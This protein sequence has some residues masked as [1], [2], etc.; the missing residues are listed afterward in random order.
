MSVVS[1][2]SASCPRSSGLGGCW[3]SISDSAVDYSN[4]YSQIV[5]AV[6]QHLN[7][8]G[9][10]TIGDIQSYGLDRIMQALGKHGEYF[11]RIANGEGSIIIHEHRETKSISSESTFAADV[12]DYELI[13]EKL[14]SLTTRVHSQLKNSQFFYKTITLKIRFED[15]TTFS[16][17]K[18]LGAYNNDKET[19]FNVSK[20]LS[21][22]FLHEKKKIRLLGIRLS[23]LRKLE[24]R[25]QTL[26]KWL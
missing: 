18:S 13:S 15:F 4:Y 21:D 12:G 2:G 17:S 7:N 8:L 3:L 22:Q 23:N 5:F 25:Q 14:N 10:K 19:I 11:W 24:R 9:I 20:Q 26:T 16:R 6:E 1:S